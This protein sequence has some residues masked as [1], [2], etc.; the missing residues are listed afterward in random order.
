MLRV[1]GGELQMK[2][3]A[4]IYFLK[5][6]VWKQMVIRDAIRSDRKVKA[7]IVRHF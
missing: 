6:D 5:D 7:R 2:K 1:Q 4:A 3:N